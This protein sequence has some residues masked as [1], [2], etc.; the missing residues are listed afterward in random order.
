MAGREGD[1][2]RLT[3]LARKHAWFLI[4]VCLMTIPCLYVARLDVDTVLDAPYPHAR[5]W[6]PV[7]HV[8]AAAERPALPRPPFLDA[9]AL[10]YEA[11]GQRKRLGPLGYSLRQELKGHCGRSAPLWIYQ[12]QVDDLA[13]AKT[14]LARAFDAAQAPPFPE[15]CSFFA[16]WEPGV[17]KFGETYAETRW[18]PRRHLMLFER[19]VL[20]LGKLQVSD[21]F[22]YS[23]APGDIVAIIP[24]SEAVEY[25]R[26]RV[27]VESKALS[28]KP[29]E[30][31]VARDRLAELE[32]RAAALR[33]TRDSELTHVLL[34]L[35]EKFVRRGPSPPLIR[36]TLIPT[37]AA[38][39]ASLGGAEEERRAMEWF[40]K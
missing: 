30:L 14:S 33:R 10:P 40:S 26:L 22:G 2:V 29:V 25:E 13:K 21:A 38:R 36:S 34:V 28:D 3:A 6:K 8:A 27:K 20:G 39:A 37:T 1:A 35:P 7:P 19:Q 15:G 5:N 4:A 24:E 9:P 23:G 17:D 11:A 31:R 16:R 32:P 18:I 12:L